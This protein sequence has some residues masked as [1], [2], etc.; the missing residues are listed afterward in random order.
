MRKHKC[1]KCGGTFAYAVTV[2]PFCGN[3][4]SVHTESWSPRRTAINLLLLPLVLAIPYGLLVLMAWDGHRAY[5]A[6]DS[7]FSISQTITFGHVGDS[8]WWIGPIVWPA[9]F[10]VAY[11]VDDFR[12][13]RG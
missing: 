10:A 12:R 1:M 3:L 7:Y 8:H 9:L 2:C 11:I 6:G 5:L 13:R 4:R